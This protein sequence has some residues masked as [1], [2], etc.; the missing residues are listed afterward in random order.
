MSMTTANPSQTWAETI[1]ALLQDEYAQS[2]NNRCYVLVDCAQQAR[3]PQ[4]LL[5][6]YPAVQWRN[7]FAASNEE[8]HLTASPL[9]F[10]LDLQQDW[11]KPLIARLARDGFELPLFTLLTSSASIDQLAIHLGQYTHTMLTT[12]D[13][14]VI[15]FY[16]P[17]ILPR[18]VEILS[19]VQ[20]SHFLQPVAKWWY[21]GRDGHM[22]FIKGMSSSVPEAVQAFALTQEQED[23]LSTVSL[24]DRIINALRDD[25][26]EQFTQRTEYALYQDTKTMIEAAMK[27]GIETWGDL[28]LFCACGFASAPEFYKH[29]KSMLILKDVQEKQ[30]TF[31][32]AIKE[33]STE[34]WDEVRALFLQQATT[35]AKSQPE[36]FFAS[37]K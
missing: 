37:R 8:A 2:P 21:V 24:P 26:E 11:F 16:D 35:A 13:A 23:A 28:R 30:V 31:G 14:V 9:L 36:P 27:F 10:A 19:E 15:R 33:V 7:L 4:S 29:P 12:Q 22:H 25:F 5:K 20:R 3:Y 18:F 1:I 32:E 6:S 34:T 17:R